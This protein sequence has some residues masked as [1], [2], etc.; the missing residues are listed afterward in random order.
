MTAI[1][2]DTLIKNVSLDGKPEEIPESTMLQVDITGI[3]TDPNLCRPGFLYVAAECE[4]VDSTRY[5]VRLDGRDFIDTAVANGAAAVLTT[6]DAGSKV[7]AAKSVISL[8]HSAPLSIMGELCSRFFGAPKP[9]HIALVTGT[10]GKTSTVNF[11]RA[12]WTRA[13][14]G[15]C[16]IGNLGGVCSDGSLVWDRDPTLSVPETVTLHRILHELALRGIN[17]VAME[18]TSHALFDYRL[19]GVPATIGAFTNLTRDHLDFHQTMEEYFRVKMLLF[20]EVLAPGSFAVLNADA[21]WFAPALAICKERQHKIISFGFKGSEVKL[22]NLEKTATGQTLTLEIYGTRY[23]TKLNLFGL[24]QA[25]NAL[26]SL[27]I[28]LASGIAAEDAVALLSTLGEV[29]GRLNTVAFTPAGGRAI[30][31]Y[32]HTPD[33]IR[34]ALEACRTFTPGKLV[35]VFG[36]NGERD[37]GKRE[38]MGAIAARLADQVIVTDGHPRSEDPASIRRDVMVGAPQ[39]MEV[40][41]RKRAIEIALQMIKEGDT[42]LIAGLGHEN[43]RTIGEEH[44]PYSDTETTKA[45]ASAMLAPEA[46]R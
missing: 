19:N 45:L 38:E 4:T 24:F 31:D 30:V 8:S 3:T 37:H 23:E 42:V 15:A 7:G 14:F 27:S 21:E 26:C 16:S 25:S 39:A 35:V 10:N 36:C 22:L 43:F 5:G 44:V 34:A 20:K 29:E 1:S 17:H 9:E 46:Q 40:D 41:D 28:A 13:G 12:L 11:S 18:A 6:P 32:A 2:L 33:G